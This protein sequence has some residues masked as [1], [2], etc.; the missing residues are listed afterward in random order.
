[1]PRQR[2]R[3]GHIKRGRG[4]PALAKRPYLNGDIERMTARVGM[5]PHL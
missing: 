3:D 4:Y 1:M 2:L 5:R